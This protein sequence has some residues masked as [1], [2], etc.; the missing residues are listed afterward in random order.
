MVFIC[1]A[2]GGALAATPERY[3]C[4]RCERAYPIHHG[5]PDF[6]LNDPP[7][8]TRERDLAEAEAIWARPDASY[9][10]LVRD[11]YLSSEAARALPY[12]LREKYI[13]FRLD[14]VARARRRL[15][16]VREV[17]RLV[18]LDVQRR[19][20]ALDL[21]CGTGGM[22][23]ALAAMVDEVW[24]V[25][26][27]LV[28]LAL[29]QRL[30][31]EQG[32]GNIHL[33]CGDS[34]HLPFP[35]G[36]FDLINANDVIEHLRDQRRGL[37]EAYRVLSDPGVFCFDSPNRLDLFGPE[38]HVNVRWVGFLPRRLQDPYVRLVKGVPYIGKRLLSLRELARLLAETVP[39]GR[40]AIVSPMV[41]DPS[42]RGRSLMGR[43][44]RRVPGVL[45]H[46]Q[47]H[48]VP[49]HEVVVWKGPERPPAG[50]PPVIDWRPRSAA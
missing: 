34:E 9:A 8:T 45:R 25:D 2:C 44:A 12:E 10:E 39:A 42:H 35:N 5:I 48:F 46:V 20:I 21:G 41:I 30:A 47:R 22:L 17:A 31:A 15:A 19:R 38:P 11:R 7:Y 14:N 43:L 23:V 16:R 3:A 6:R 1:P 26:I 13:R 49:R 32:L 50:Y 4:T 18:G 37:A 27:A 24:G 40:Y 36:T 33:V 28:N 29:A